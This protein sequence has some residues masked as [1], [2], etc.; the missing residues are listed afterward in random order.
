MTVH[1]HVFITPG[2]VCKNQVVGLVDFDVMPP[3]K[4]LRV[5]LFNLVSVSVSVHRRLPTGRNNRIN[6]LIINSV[7]HMRDVG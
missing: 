2:F 3:T 5:T 7:V 4:P 6:G 1:L